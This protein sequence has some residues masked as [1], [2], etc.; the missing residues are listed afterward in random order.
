M[1]YDVEDLYLATYLCCFLAGCRKKVTKAGFC[2]FTFVLD[3]T[4][5]GSLFACFMCVCYFV[6]FFVG[7]HF[8]RLISEI[9]RCVKLGYCYVDVVPTT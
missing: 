2:N 8:G 4:S 3:L 5:F 7:N 9:T 6:S 1:H